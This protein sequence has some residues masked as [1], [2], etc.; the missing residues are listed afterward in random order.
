MNSLQQVADESADYWQRRKTCA[1]DR[2]APWQVPLTF[3]RH[4]N[5]V[6]VQDSLLCGGT[7]SR[8]LWPYI[9]RP[10]W[11]QYDEFCYPSSPFGGA[12]V[13]LAST[14]A[15]LRR[16]GWPGAQDKV[17][18]III[19]D[20][21]T[22]NN[23]ADERELQAHRDKERPY[24]RMARELGARILYNQDPQRYAARRYAEDGVRVYL[25]PNGFGTHVTRQAL[26][27][28]AASV[29]DRF[30]VFDHCICAVGS[31]TLIRSLQMARHYGPGAPRPLSRQFHGVCVYAVPQDQDELRQY[32]G[33]EAEP[34]DPKLCIQETPRI[35][36]LPPYAS[37][38]HYDAKC[39]K[40]AQQLAGKVLI[41]NV[42]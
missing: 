33:P 42:M 28:L 27:R 14:M 2:Q 13:A 24:T 26:A 18:S 32:I 41:W 5:C 6:I 15:F 17:A 38:L 19:L 10:R 25:I 11:E 1:Q 40:F 30:G 29:R 21:W 12:Q 22:C 23:K 20:N 31:G 34:I 36:E 35:S 37:C 16:H 7:K 4:Q 3:I 39:W 9:L 8:L